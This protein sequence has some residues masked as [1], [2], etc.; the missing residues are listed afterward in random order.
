MR[1]ARVLVLT[2]FAAC[3]D[4][5][6]ALTD[7]TDD[8]V[9]DTD[10]DPS[11]DSDAVDT[12]PDPDDSDT[13]D[14]STPDPVVVCG[15]TIP[16]PQLGLCSVEPGEGTSTLY[17]GIV[18]EPVGVL[19]GGSVL[20]DAEGIITCVG[21][22]CATAPGFS[23]A[24]VVDC[25]DGVISPG[26]INPHE[27]LTFSEA[28]PFP[29][30][31]KRYN[32][33]HDWRAQLSTPSN[34]HGTGS[35]SPGNRWVELRH[36]VA[37]TTSIV[38]SG[39]ATGMVRNPDE[40]DAL[41]APLPKVVNQTFPLGD[42]N[43]RFEEDCGWDYKYS[44]RDIATYEHYLPHVAEGI[45]DFASEE[46]RCQSTSFDGGQDTT[47]AN[48]AHI[49]SIGLDAVD[50]ADMVRGGTSMVWSPRSNI[51]LYGHTANV[52]LFA[53]LG[54]TI[55]LGTDWSYTGSAHIVRELVCADD[56][57]R[58][59]YDGFFSDGALWRMATSGAATAI[60]ARGVLGALEEGLVADLAIFDGRDHRNHRA[61]ITAGNED[62]ILVARAGVPLF[63][64]ATT[65]ERLGHA[66]DPVDV[67]GSERRLCVDEEWDVSF[68]S[69]VAQT[70]GAYP[71]F[72]CDDTPDDE[73]TCVPSRPGE[74]D[75]K[76]TALDP[77]G[78]GIPTDNDLCPDVFDPIRPIDGGAQPDADQDGLGDACDPT[79][80]LP[81]L[82]GDGVANSID[83]CPLVSD[84]QADGDSDGKGDACD[85]CPAS[86]NPTR[87][88]AGLDSI[89]EARAQGDGASVA[90]E[91]VVT[92]VG[93]QGYSLQ[94][95]SVAGG[96]NAGIYVF[97]GGAPGVL[98]GERVRV[99]GQL[100]DYNGELQL[101]EDSTDELGTATPITPVALTVAQAV[102]E[103]YE[104]VLVRI[105]DGT[106]SNA[107]YS[108]AVDGACSDTALWEVGGPSGLVLYNRYYAGGDWAS[109]TGTLPATGVMGW[110]WNRR[111][112]MPR[113]AADF[114]P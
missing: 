7:D 83:V 72:F 97:T 69:L 71:L 75:G 56:L 63:G 51:S 109:Q 79:P 55:A 35:T 26:L 52:R 100:E 5:G 6:P 50:Y 23:D 25:P 32:H 27:H 95:P 65:L 18:L 112:L 41:G 67:C 38:G 87:G 30:S 45:N 90:V 16:A 101:E 53:T 94:D 42:S 40:N 3:R 99:S 70:P 62:V 88:C 104:H 61:V 105:T 80:L 64:E 84:N 24:T 110:R 108:C 48:V 93:A 76:G 111:R 47:E 14:P 58:D 19:D 73:P 81:D 43:R 2:W 8:T 34:A 98:V 102:D 10:S 66:C 28:P 1:L 21:C 39:R 78:D 13:I 36:L 96:R 22:D 60:G 20:V 92:G 15:T 44:E 68:A 85:A 113:S 114:A 103:A 107:A 33:R 106:V 17:R 37:G 57:N 74:F 91:G 4:T 12:D 9:V 89:P 49:H 77:D 29:P 11:V 31:A 59:H 82:D 46:Y 86:A 54:G